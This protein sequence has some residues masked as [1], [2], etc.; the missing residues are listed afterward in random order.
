MTIAFNPN[1]Y[2]YEVYYNLYD[3]DP[4]LVATFRTYDEA[5]EYIE[6]AKADDVVEFGSLDGDYTI[7]TA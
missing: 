2:A 6:Q 4:V 7:R 3:N 5:K 1:E